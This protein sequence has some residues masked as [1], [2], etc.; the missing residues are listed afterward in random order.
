MHLMQN[1]SLRFECIV[2][3]RRLQTQIRLI[4]LARYFCVGIGSQ[5]DLLNC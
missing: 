1:N 2:S 5:I 3:I 4:V